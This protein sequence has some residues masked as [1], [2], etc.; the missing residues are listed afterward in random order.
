MIYLN[1]SAN[2]N[3]GLA[4]RCQGLFLPHLQSQGKAPWG[5]S[6]VNFYVRVCARKFY[7]RKWNRGNLWGVSLKREVERDSTFTF[8]RDLSYTVPVP[9]LFV[10]VNFAH[11]LLLEFRDCGNQPLGEWITFFKCQYY[12]LLSIPCSM[13]LQSFWDFFKINQSSY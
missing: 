4:S 7:W 8:T 12:L 9:L 11:V 3:D 6:W 13:S 5:R 1:Q 2:Q 10:S